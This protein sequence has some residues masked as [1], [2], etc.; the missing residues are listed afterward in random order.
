MHGRAIAKHTCLSRVT[1][2]FADMCVQALD[3]MAEGP[4]FEAVKKDDVEVSVSV[5]RTTG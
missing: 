2:L 3:K 4:L 1:L 5:M